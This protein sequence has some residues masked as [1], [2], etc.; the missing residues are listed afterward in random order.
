MN[1]HVNDKEG[2]FED[3]L[4]EIPYYLREKVSK[5]I[6]EKVEER[7]QSQMSAFK[8]EVLKELEDQRAQNQAHIA[9]Y[10]EHPYHRYNYPTHPYAYGHY[11]R[12]GY[13]YPGYH[14]YD[15]YRYSK[16]PPKTSAEN[17]NQNTS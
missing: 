10:L 3:D 12:P 5:L 4:Q 7:V 11:G 17:G 14:P 16:S 15:G 8:E 1:G 6:D 9:H 2:P 13:G